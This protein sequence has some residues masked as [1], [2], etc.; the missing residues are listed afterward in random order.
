[1]AHL[2]HTVSSRSTQAQ[3]PRQPSQSVHPQC[4]QTWQSSPPQRGQTGGSIVFILRVLRA[5]VVKTCFTFSLSLPQP[6]FDADAG[7]FGFADDR[8]A[9]LGHVSWHQ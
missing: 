3:P 4:R 8:A 9:Q 7:Q 2:L 6:G 5:L 1:M